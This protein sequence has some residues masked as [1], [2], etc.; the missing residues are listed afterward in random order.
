MHFYCGHSYNQRSLGDN[1]AECPICAPEFRC[2]LFRAKGSKETLRLSMQAGVGLWVQVMLLRLLLTGL[3]FLLPLPS[4]CPWSRRVLDIKRS[5]A[6]AAAQQDRF[7]TELREAG[8]GFSVVA[9]H[10]GRGLMNMTAAAEAA[11]GG[12]EGGFVML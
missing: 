4:P 9:E 10:L 2:V 7:F 8:D 12:G 5:M 11:A 1:D 3:L 6:A